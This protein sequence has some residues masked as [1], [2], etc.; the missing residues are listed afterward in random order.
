[1]AQMV[2]RNLDDAVLAGLKRRAAANRTSAEEEA[3][4]ALTASIG[5]DAEAWRAQARVVAERI[6]SLPG[7]DSTELLRADRDRDDHP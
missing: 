6:G 1:M 2:I 4:R 5:F 7:P 3:R